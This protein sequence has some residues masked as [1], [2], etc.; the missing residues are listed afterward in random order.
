PT[1]RGCTR[2]SRAA[3]ASI[4]AQPRR[5]GGGCATSG[6]S[7]C[8]SGR[9]TAATSPEA[10][11]V[12]FVRAN[13]L[14][15]FYADA[16]AGPPLLLLMGHGLDHSFWAK[17]IPVYAPHFRCLALDNRGI[18]QSDVPP[19]G[20]SVD[21]MATDTFG[22]MDALGVDAAHVA[23]FSM[24]GSIALAMAARL[25]ERVLTLSLHSTCGRPYPFLKHRYRV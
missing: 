11:E 8:R 18:G 24:G 3:G 10:A 16:G 9:S 23:G 4:S 1:E 19:A 6:A 15:L 7:A 14:R 17:Q 5:R 25:P 21:D 20:Y 2:C 13:G 12:P 22:V